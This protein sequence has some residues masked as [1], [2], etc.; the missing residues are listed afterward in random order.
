[1]PLVRVKHPGNKEGDAIGSSV[2]EGGA[3]RWNWAAPAAP[4]AGE[5]EGEGVG[6]TRVRFVCSVGGRG[7][8][9]GWTAAPGGGRRWSDCSGEV[10]APLEKR[11]SQRA[12]VGARGGGG[13]LGW[14]CGWSEPGA[15]RGSI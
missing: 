4:L 7:L 2:M 14:V 5:V 15:R 11:A 8:L 13:G 12:I 9:V 10:A 6:L 1:M 3:A